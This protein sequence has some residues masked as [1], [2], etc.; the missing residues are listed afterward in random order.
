MTMNTMAAA[1]TNAY[2]KNV[3]ERPYHLVDVISLTQYYST[4]NSNIQFQGLII[5]SLFLKK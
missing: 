2:P 1:Q 4:T 3:P 5:I